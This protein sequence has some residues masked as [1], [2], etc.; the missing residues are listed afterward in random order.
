MGET[1]QDI[2]RQC[3]NDAE[4]DSAPFPEI[5]G[6]LM[7][8]GVEAYRIDFRRNDATY[9]HAD[10]GTLALPITDVGTAIPPDFNAEAVRAAVR[11]AQA[12]QPGYT[13]VGFCRKVR[14]AGC[15]SYFTSIEG[16][17]VVYSGRSGDMLVERFPD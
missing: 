4:D 9:Y 13:Y 11:E 6:R 17:R 7:N 15:E 3:L 2:A 5:L 1:W 8:A 12:L 10:L 16:R 14:A